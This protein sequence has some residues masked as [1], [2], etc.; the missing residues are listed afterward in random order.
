MLLDQICANTHTQFVQHTDIFT[1]QTTYIVLCGVCTVRRR[2]TKTK[3]KKC[4]W[5][6]RVYMNINESYNDLYKFL[7]HT[8]GEQRSRFCCFYFHVEPQF[9]MIFF[10][11]LFT[12]ANRDFFSLSLSL[13]L[14]HTDQSA[15]NM[16]NSDGHGYGAQKKVFGSGL[17]V[18]NVNRICITVYLQQA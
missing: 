15:I 7:L 14:V 10:P 12:S 6:K 18:Y 4:D 5:E 2:Q 13:F 9:C 8:S 16:N 17:S 3:K 1:T 11:W